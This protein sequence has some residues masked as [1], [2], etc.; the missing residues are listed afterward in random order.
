MPII[1]DSTRP[2][3]A[4][5][6]RFGSL[7]GRGTAFGVLGGVL[8]VVG[9]LRWRKA[10][11]RSEPDVSAAGLATMRNGGSDEPKLWLRLLPMAGLLSCAA[12]GYWLFVL[13][14]A[15]VRLLPVENTVRYQGAAL[16]LVIGA[17][18]SVCRM[19][20][21]GVHYARELFVQFLMLS[22]EGSHPDERKESSQ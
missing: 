8:M 2:H 7:Y 18:V 20:R 4:T 19:H 1:Y 14:R 10:A 11:P 6:G 9:S 3:R 21:F 17:A 22:A 13:L 5:I 15:G 12:G 16:L